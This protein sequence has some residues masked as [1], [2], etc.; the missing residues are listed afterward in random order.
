[1]EKTYYDF[2]NE[3]SAD[4]L[5]ERLVQY[6]MFSEKLPPILS[7]E[8]FLEYCKNKRAQP[9]E[10]KWYGYITY[11]NVRNINVPRNLGIPTPMGHE[12]LCKCISENWDQ[13]LLHFREKTIANPRVISRIHIRKMKDTEALFEMN[14]KNWK[15]DGTPEPEI[16]M[17]KKYMVHADISKC[18]PSIYS[19]AIPWA[20]IGKNEAKKY[21]HDERLWYNKID[22]Y[23][24]NSKNGETHGLLI[25]PH[26]SNVLSEIILCSIDERLSKEYSCYIRNID[27]YI[28]YTDSRDEA[29]TF[30][31]DLNRELREFDL[32]INHKKTEIL[33]LPLC[34][35]ETWVHKIQNQLSV[36]HS[37]KEYVD[38]KDI[39]AYVD[40][41][42]RLASENYENQSILYYAIKA[43]KDYNLTSNAKIYLIKSTVSLALLYPYLVPSL[44]E[45]IFEAYEVNE[46]MIGEYANK[47]FDKYITKNNF[48]ACAYAILYAI[49][50]N[51]KIHH[52]NLDEIIGSKDCILLL[53]ALIYCKK[54]KWRSGVEKLKRLA[55][56]IIANNEMEQYWLFVYECLGQGALEGD[57]AAMKKAKVSFLKQE[58]K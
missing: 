45:Y 36:F 53:L 31:R 14:Y 10:D 3:I 44:G 28:C 47:I 6:G 56:K 30:L 51:A 49:K 4:E 42:V 29:E 19:H 33:E 17:G 50:T 22:K 7:A 32:L 54:N 2:M 20:L 9:F 57:W 13:V 52:F 23:T 37:R 12:M 11:E 18:F 5:Y 48:E 15:T 41:A 58:F 55:K 38:Y 1:M 25:G 40:F 46:E 26:T 35:A 43:I 39:Q 27:D 21:T 34:V 24:R 16:F 8:S